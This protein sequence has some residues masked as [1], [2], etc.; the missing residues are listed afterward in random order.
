[1]NENILL[2]TPYLKKNTYIS[3]LDKEVIL[4]L[5]NINVKN[6][7]KYRDYYII[8]LYLNN[9]DNINDITEIDE[10]ILNIYSKKNKKWFDNELSKNELNEL[11]FK[12]YCTHTSTTDIILNN[13]TI[14]IKNN[15]IVDL[16]NDII[17]ELKNN[18][19][20]IEIEQKIL[21]IYISKKSIKIKWII[22]KIY[23]DTIIND[24][25]LNKEELENEWIDTFNETVEFLENKK[26]EY[27]KRMNNI[28]VFKKNNSELLNEIKNITNKKSWNQKI[29]ILKNNIKNILSINDNR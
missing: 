22:T 18:D 27:T 7:L 6:I 4:K 13:D 3:E 15:K 24:M 28:E 12:S 17:T 23:I 1:M 9:I 2:K 10:K 21:G 20:E 26:I 11:F 19:I 14:I 25:E 5:T 16:N 8:Q 29:N